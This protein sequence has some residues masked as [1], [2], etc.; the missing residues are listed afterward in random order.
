MRPRL[1]RN[2]I[3]LLCMVLAVCTALC[4]RAEKENNAMER[5]VRKPAVAGQFY[6][7]NPAALETE[8]RRYLDAAG[9]QSIEGRVIAI[10]SPHAGYIY[11]GP[12][13]AFGYNLIRGRNYETVV[14][15]APSHVEYFD[16]SSVFPGSS[17]VTPL[18]EIPVDREMVEAVT[19]HSDL[20]RADTRGHV[21]T[22]GGRGEHSLEVQLP[23]LQVALGD[24][25]LVA[26]VM[27]D[28][29]R[30][31]VEA[32]GDALARALAGRNALIVASTDLSHFHDDESARRLDGVFMK[33]LEEFDSEKLLGSLAGKDTEACGG[34]PTAVALIASRKL[35]AD[36]CAVLRYANSGDVTGDTRSVVGYVSAAM[37]DTE[38]NEDVERSGNPHAEEPG[39]SDGDKSF[40][41]SLARRVI[42]AE[43]TGTQP[44]I[45]PPPS[46]I[47]R[48]KRGAFVTLKK[49]GQLRGCIG[50]IEAVKPLIS[51]I[52]E[53]ARSAAF[54]DWRFKPVTADEVSDLEIEI[55]I[56]SPI[57]IIDDP[58][59]I[60][61]GTHG[62]IITRGR[63]RGLLLP[64][65]AVEWGWQREQFL[66][67]TCIK[68]GLPAG[69]WKD[70]GTRIEVFSAEIFSEREL[71][72]H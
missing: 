60:E 41:L 22:A 47:L 42:E 54:K 25:K 7:G 46:P 64:Q 8:V 28:Q 39:L 14:V 34:G 49:N 10:V 56:L 68:A 40:L 9:T 16:Y 61:V 30:N 45:D 29:D 59:V 58:S 35:G 1:E 55:S 11:S 20:V 23:F 71:G 6:T 13:A 12:V 63:N 52:D 43:C 48:E 51:T 57:R 50:Y 44:K 31:N 37:L 53:M 62:I 70:D 27:G 67:Q 65:V 15:I 2:T 33:R 5:I 18:G 38:R 19:A 4:A 66:D 21:I 26:I 24:F 17:Y 3:V 72:L 36:T 32:L 69:A